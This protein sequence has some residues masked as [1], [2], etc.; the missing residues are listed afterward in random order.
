MF[1]V[2]DV[3]FDVAEVVAPQAARDTAT[4]KRIATGSLKL[5]GVIL[6]TTAPR[7]NNFSGRLANGFKLLQFTCYS[8]HAEDYSFAN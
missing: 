4:G 7:L 5:L 6:K 1:V 3:A 8:T 2:F